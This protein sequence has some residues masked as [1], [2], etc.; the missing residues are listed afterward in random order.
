DVIYVNSGQ[1]VG[2]SGEKVFND[3]VSGISADANVVSGPFDGAVHYAAALKRFN[4]L[5]LTY[6]GSG[7]KPAAWGVDLG[8]SFPVM[9][10][11][12]RFGVG[13]QGTKEALSVGQA[14]GAN[15]STRTGLPKTRF[16]ANYVVNLSKCT[17]LGVEV[18]NDKAYGTDK[19]GSN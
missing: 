16:L 18:Y 3:R 6:N 19:T 2:T 11:T 17:D 4:T 14:T 5:D 13:Y 10:H 7:A 9:D 1:P 8:F 12:S 15:G